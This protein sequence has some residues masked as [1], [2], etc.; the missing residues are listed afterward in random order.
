MDKFFNDPSIGEESI[1]LI[2]YGDKKK[3]TNGISLMIKMNPAVDKR[4]II[5]DREEL[6]ACLK[7]VNKDWEDQYP[8]Q[9]IHE[10]LEDD[11]EH[12]CPK[13]G[14][15]PLYQDRHDQA[16]KVLHCDDCGQEVTL[17]DFMC[18]PHKKY[19]DNLAKVAEEYTNSQGKIETWYN[20]WQL[21]EDK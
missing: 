17:K 5:L 8:F 13:C 7:A 19:L 10:H 2:S 16:K 6:E 1:S 18:I 15:G 4:E 9:D 3:K 21:H 14:G 12:E 20:N 11:T